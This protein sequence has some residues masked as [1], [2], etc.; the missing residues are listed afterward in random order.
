MAD[1]EVKIT[2]KTEA[3]TK[4]SKEV[5]KSLEE[6]KKSADEVK[7]SVDIEKDIDAMVSSLIE[8]GQAFD[9]QDPEKFVESFRN[10][11]KQLESVDESVAEAHPEIQQLRIELDKLD[12]EFGNLDVKDVKKQFDEI[13][14]AAEGAGKS[15]NNIQ[16][17]Q[18]VSALSEVVSSSRQG[19]NELFELNE[20]VNKNDKSLSDFA[21][22]ADLA[23]GSITQIATA[24]RG[25]F[26][27]LGPIGVVL[28][29]ITV[30]LPLLS[31][32][33][34]DNTA[35]LE[36]N[37]AAERKAL[38]EKQ[39]H[40]EEIKQQKK[41]VE[42]AG[43]AIREELDKQQRSWDQVG[44]EINDA[45]AALI[46]NKNRQDLIANAELGLALAE[47]E[48]SGGSTLD[49]LRREVE[50][51]RKFEIEQQQRDEELSS[52]KIKQQTKQIEST[53]LEILEL[54][55]RLQDAELRR[56]NLEFDQS[57]T[58]EASQKLERDKQDI[59]LSV[60]SFSKNR[61][62]QT[63]LDSFDKKIKPR[64][65]S[66]SDEDFLLRSQEK[67]LEVVNSDRFKNIDGVKR[68][69]DEKA[70]N[71]KILEDLA[72]VNNLIDRLKK[73]QIEDE[74]LTDKNNLLEK[75]SKEL[76]TIDIPSL[77]KLIQKRID[78]RANLLDQRNNSVQNL[79][80]QRA[81]NVIDNRRADIE[82]GTKVSDAEERERIK[83]EREAKRLEDEKRRE[84]DRKKAE[85]AKAGRDVLD[86]AKLE[87]LKLNVDQLESFS[88]ASQ[89][90]QD[91]DQGGEINTLIDL[92]ERM[93]KYVGRNGD[94]TESQKEQARQL[95][96]RV[97]SL[98]AKVSLIE[99][100]ERNN[101]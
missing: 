12:K 17:L 32:V 50:I 90:L 43:K 18:A 40:N 96:Q 64:S 101:R 36:R 70:A 30:A 71:Q 97:D 81:I 24:G 88:T 49:K 60:D 5:K 4:G 2:Y 61:T 53:D 73:S 3:D 99:S 62:R 55:K 56:L 77:E 46:E 8:V 11:R 57:K 31:K 65:E 42:D 80:N 28:T 37:A 26:L 39:A 87:N 41:A 48:A 25:A 20:I 29:A 93:L 95:H 22:A 78:D 6:V 72:N 68:S 23:I 7:K 86:F 82:A 94:I 89:N 91:G 79:T 54:K 47:N 1:K 13:N 51:R 21:Q 59:K 14:N 98:S 38:E 45:T 84:E 83:R 44:E 74:K 19:A 34:E 85:E 75:E 16:A 52:Q 15:L 66:E 92:L 69:F 58:S 63:K 10:F 33:L 100:R 67:L 35:E 76:Q 27:A 9:A